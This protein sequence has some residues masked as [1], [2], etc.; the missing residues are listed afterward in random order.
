[1]ELFKDQ[2]NKKNLCNFTFPINYINL[3]HVEKG[4]GFLTDQ[5][6]KKGIY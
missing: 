3:K 6:D 1:M 2:I 4:K 5:I